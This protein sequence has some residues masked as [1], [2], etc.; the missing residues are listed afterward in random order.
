MAHFY[1]REKI[2]FLSLVAVNPFAE[3]FLCGCKLLD[4]GAEIKNKTADGAGEGEAARESS[5]GSRTT[6]Q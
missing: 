5:R 6:L 3:F 1:V 4:T 2:R